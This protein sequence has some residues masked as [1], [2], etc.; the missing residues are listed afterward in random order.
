VRGANS[1]STDYRNTPITGLPATAVHISSRETQGVRELHGLV[2]Q[3]RKG[4]KQGVTI[5]ETYCR[6]CGELTKADWSSDCCGLV[7]VS[8]QALPVRQIP[9]SRSLAF[10]QHSP[11]KHNPTVRAPVSGFVRLSV[12]YRETVPVIPR[13]NWIAPLRLEVYAQPTQLHL[14]AYYRR[15]SASI[16]HRVACNRTGDRSQPR[17]PHA[18]D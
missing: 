18:C 17:R 12:E 2:A 4:F 11:E 8:G 5:I 7:P 1:S 13:L 16:H 6:T 3:W 10:I 9:P 14:R 15:C